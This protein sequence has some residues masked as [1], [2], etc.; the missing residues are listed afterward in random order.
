M[1]TLV[2]SRQMNQRLLNRT[3]PS[4]QR[5][6]TLVRQFDAALKADRN[7]IDLRSTVAWPTARSMRLGRPGSATL[8]FSFADD[9]HRYRVLFPRTDLR[10][11][12]LW[13]ASPE[14]T[15]EKPVWTLMERW[16]LMEVA[17]GSELLARV[18]DHLENLD[19]AIV[20]WLDPEPEDFPSWTADAAPRAAL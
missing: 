15:R 8:T 19:D 5:R 2:T 18:Y 1:S 12:S 20:R 14:S 9:R 4:R 11:I 17:S 13:V 16:S 10:V 7:V 3:P 6:C